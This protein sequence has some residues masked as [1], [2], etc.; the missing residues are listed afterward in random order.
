MPAASP[1]ARSPAFV[2]TLLLAAV[3]VTALGQTLV[4]T[5][6]PSLG[7]STGLAEIQVGLIISCSSL[8]FALAS[9][10]WGYLSEL[11]G[12]RPVLI[13][14]LTG[15]AVGTVF[16]AVVFHL[17]LNGWLT[18]GALVACLVV[19][20]MSQAVIMAA[21]PPA[22]AAYTADITAPEARTRGMGRIGAANNLGTVLG[23]GIGG[24]LAA[25]TLILPLYLVAG[26]VACMAL[27]IFLL[28]PPSP[29][30][31]QAPDTRV[32]SVM[33]TGLRAYTDTRFRDLLITGVVLFMSFAL[34][35]Q[36]L[37]FLFQDALHMSPSAAAGALGTAMMAAAVTSLTGQIL[38]VQWLRAPAL[39]LLAM[40]VPLIGAG[41]LLLWLFD[42]RLALTGAVMLVGLG[43]GFGMPAIMA[44]AS[45]RVDSSEQGRVA[46]LASACPSLGFIIGPLTGTALYSVD[47][48]FPYIMV[49]VL[50]VP[51]AVLVWRLRR[52]TETAPKTDLSGED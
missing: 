7:R 21:T 52:R 37:G 31:T 4:F 25:L 44:L 12:R 34:V 36:T 6:L 30:R 50:M 33:A 45:L 5:L 20:R 39:V 24:L 51:L 43:I 32:R 8:A 26:V 16:F 22:A 49:A 19:A 47:H 48:R 18:G 46:G 28:L 11:Y 13:I 23:P 40:A 42:Q 29:Y 35:Q 15:Y 10:I 3:G 38:V 9:P 17:G 1:A 14:G 2:Q 27:L 41:A